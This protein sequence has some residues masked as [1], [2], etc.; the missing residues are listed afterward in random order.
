MS[1]Y[2]RSGRE[3]LLSHCPWIASSHYRVVLRG[4]T[5]VAPRRPALSWS[6][7]PSTGA[8]V[9]SLS[10]GRSIDCT[11]SPGFVPAERGIETT[12]SPAKAAE[13]VDALRARQVGQ[14][15]AEG[16][17]ALPLHPPLGGEGRGTFKFQSPCWK[18]RV[19][20]KS[21]VR[22]VHRL[23]HLTRFR[24][25]LGAGSKPPSPPQGRRRGWTR[26]ARG[27]QPPSMR[28]DRRLGR[29]AV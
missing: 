24:S 27:D 28:V 17:V 26:C 13:R 10:W 19:P 3:A 5:G 2:K 21:F 12:L 14:G 6:K 9:G 8:G 29:I 1:L 4:I 7:G 16:S 11:T 23:H 22:T 15:V 18:H 20:S 25:R